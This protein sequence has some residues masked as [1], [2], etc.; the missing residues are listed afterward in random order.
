MIVQDALQ[1]VQKAAVATMFIM[2]KTIKKL[3]DER[4]KFCIGIYAE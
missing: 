3:S 4:A 2:S 1:P